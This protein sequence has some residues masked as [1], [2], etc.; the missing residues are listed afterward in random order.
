MQ[1]PSTEYWQAGPVE[2][3]PALLQP[4]AHALLQS[5]REVEEALHDFPSEKLWEKP[6]GVASVGFHVRHIAGVT[7]RLFTYA[8]AQPLNEQQMSFLKQE[9]TGEDGDTPQGLVADL[10]RQ[11]EKAIEQ[12]RRLP[13]SVLAEHRGV[14]R[15]QLP[16]TVIGLLFHAAEHA[17]RHTGQLLVTAQVVKAMNR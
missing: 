3:V 6:Y 1:H 17:Q 11:V 8:F 14:G 2:G 5:A 7:D 12:L 13:E 10:F 16:S 4:V 9:A 15:K